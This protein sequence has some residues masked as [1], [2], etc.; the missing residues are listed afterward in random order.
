MMTGNGP[1]NSA[2]AQLSRWVRKARA[3]AVVLAALLLSVSL[4][5]VPGTG[6]AES[7][8]ATHAVAARLGGGAERTRFVVDLT[9]AVDYSAKVLADPYRVIIDLPEVK[10]D[11][12]PGLGRMGR[13]LVKEYR[14]G[15]FGEG[16]S[17]IVLDVT[18]PVLVAKSFVITARNNQPAR[19]VIDL[20]RTDVRRSRHAPP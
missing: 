17:R 7:G 3:G 5:G 20:R 19:L 14:Y 18:G 13:G 2:V 11:F 4:A 9:R 8:R 15:Q 1:I 16:K 10:F 12:P 6:H